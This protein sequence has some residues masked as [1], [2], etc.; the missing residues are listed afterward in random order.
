[1][2]NTPLKYL[3]S[4]WFSVVMGLAGLALAWHRAAP[5]MGDMAATVAALLG[6]LAAAVFVLLALAS[7]L[8]AHQ[9]PQAWAEDLH[10]P[11]R[12]PFVAA[13]PVSVLLLATVAV[14]MMGPSAWVRAL[15]WLGSVAQLAT[16][17]WVVSRWWRGNQAGGL[18]WAG[19]TPALLIPIVGNVLAPLAGV[20]LGH[21]AWAT[22]QLG[23]GLMFWPV[24]VVLILVR[25]A[26]VGLWPER[27]RPAV[28]VLIAP[29]AVVG[30][31]LMQLGAPDGV[32]WA[33]WGMALFCTAWAAT[34]GKA[35]ASQPLG[36]PHWALSFPLAAATALTLRLA[37]T[38]PALLMPAVALLALTTLV[39]AALL[40]GTLRGLR[41]GSLLAPEPVAMI[42]AAP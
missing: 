6:G 42:Q 23:V 28:F 2:S 15:W 38:S 24:V 31:A 35:I 4:A 27:L 26:T 7:L 13:I 30:L 8:R 33:M 25:V 1:M 22:A 17:V 37:E 21:S 16:T 3:G 20:P 14:T 10:H 32:A 11:V 40:L 34:Q 18:Q 19:V 39:V 9:H 5:L 12:H 29:P 41:N 36:M